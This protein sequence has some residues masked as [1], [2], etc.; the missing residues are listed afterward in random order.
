MTPH[1][2]TTHGSVCLSDLSNG[3]VCGR[4]LK[5]GFRQCRFSDEPQPSVAD[6]R[7][8]LNDNVLDE[9]SRFGR[10]V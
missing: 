1:N 7:D 5:I 10:A 6:G 4:H 9:K 2:F 8:T 3:F